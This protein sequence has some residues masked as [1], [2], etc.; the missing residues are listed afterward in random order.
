M[1][2]YAKDHIIGLLIEK[3]AF[4]TSC[5]DQKNTEEEEEEEEEWSIAY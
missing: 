2:L 1:E 5:E 4:E 3:I